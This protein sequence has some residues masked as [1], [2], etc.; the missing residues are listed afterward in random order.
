MTIIRTRRLV[1]RRIESA[2]APA[3]VKICN[4]PL[5]ARNTARIP[6]PYTLKDAQAF[7]AFAAEAFANGQEFPFIATEDGAIVASCGVM[8]LKDG[9]FELGYWVAANARGRGVASEA[10]QA[11]LAFA[12]KALGAESIDAGYFTD[13]PASGRVLEKLGFRYN[14]EKRQQFSIGRGASADCARMTLRRADFLAPGLN[15]I[16]VDTSE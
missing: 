1:L 3:L 6:A 14:G 16:T 8:A 10:A 4:D 7:I 9:T 15:D 11:V 12:F 13:N 5:I 2:D